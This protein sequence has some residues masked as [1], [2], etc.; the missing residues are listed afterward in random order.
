MIQI[1]DCQH[2]VETTTLAYKR[3]PDVCVTC[4]WLEKHP[5][6]PACASETRKVRSK[7]KKEW[8]SARKGIN[9]V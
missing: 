7:N 1:R 2:S 4:R 9:H 5:T 3:K 6:T 8:W